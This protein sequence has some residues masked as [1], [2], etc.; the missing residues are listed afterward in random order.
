MFNR[1]FCLIMFCVS[2]QVLSAQDSLRVRIVWGEAGESEMRILRTDLDA[3]LVTLI[4]SLHIAHHLEAGLDSLVES[5]GLA[6]AYMH[7]GPRYQDI[8]I[9][10]NEMAVAYAGGDLEAHSYAYED[11]LQLKKDL[12]SKADNNGYPFAE[13][14]FV[15]I[16][17]F[18]NK[19]S[20][21]MQLI[22]NRKVLI[23]S[24]TIIGDASVSEGFLGP[25]L[26]LAVGK[27][28]SKKQV[29]QASNRLNNLPF[30]N[31]KK[32][33]NIVF[34]DNGADVYIFAEDKNASR[35]DALLGVLPVND[36]LLENSVILT[37]TALIDL[38]NT[39]DRGERI[40]FEFKQ[41]R[42]LTQ[43]V[44]AQV[45]Y[46]YFFGLPFGL[47]SSFE[48]SKQDTTFLDVD[49]TV[50]A[51]YLFG[52]DNHIEVFFASDISRILDVNEAAVISNRTLPNNL[53]TRT[54]YYGVQTQFH[55]LANLTNPRSGW[56]LRNKF[57]L[58]VKQIRESSLILDLVDP[59]DTTF[60]FRELY[61][62]FENQDQFIVTLDAARYQPIGQQSALKVG[63][64][65]AAILGKAEVFTNERF[66]VG[67]NQLLRGFN[68][69]NF[70]TDRYL[71]NTLE[72]R[73]TLQG[74]SVLFAFS[75]LAVLQLDKSSNDF[76][77]PWGL[78][79]GIN[80]ETGAGILSLSAAV[81]RDLSVAEDFF[82]L[83]R[84]RIHV[85]YVNL[86]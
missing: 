23:K 44:K 86:F 74:N 49:Y 34:K 62:D 73:F 24:I 6:K 70:F 71:V 77:Y 29:L 53:D 22:L 58:G 19:V 13:I 41:L 7:K 75:D 82:D 76:N 16:V 50:G 32:P 25:Y 31:S 40:F 84:P 52:G 78:G 11:A 28:L 15:D 30:I 69:Q 68:E 80:F 21:E 43:E 12:L 47:R 20:A 17:I 35:F 39:L 54:Q 79:A 5:D 38:V 55:N 64:N 9:S 2:A 18:E 8:D 51:Q 65:A 4:D 27:P 45:S 61:D 72:Y 48:L 63:L 67:G 83:G 57:M 3:K 56:L 60:D 42:P 14:K 46:P 1:I 10:L 33:P 85:G 26:G 59:E 37:A 66:R 36:P 81:G